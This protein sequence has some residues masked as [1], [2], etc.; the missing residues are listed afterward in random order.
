M[1]TAIRYSASNK[2]DRRVLTVLP[3]CVLLLVFLGFFGATARAQQD[4]PK[5]PPPTRTDSV[6]EDIHGIM[7]A[8]PY[9]W[10]EDQQS[11]E[12]RAW[13]AAENACT[14][15]V[16]RNLAG[17]AAIEKRLTEL[18][19]VDQ[20][21]VPSARHG[22]YFF[23]KR[24][25]GQDLFVLYMRAGR[26]GRDEVLVDPASMSADH[27]T[28]VNFL[29]ASNDGRLV[30]FGVRQGGED[31]ISIRLLNSE[32]HKEL[33]D[34]LPRARY[35]ANDSGSLALKPDKSGFYYSKMTSGG[36]RIFYHSIGSDASSDQEVFGKQYGPDKI[37]GVRLSPDGKYLLY[38]VS[39]GAGSER[40]EVY[41]QNA[42]DNGPVAT[43]VNDVDAFTFARIA[44]DTIYLL[45][46]WNAPRW[47][48]MAADVKNPGRKHWREIIPESDARIEG[49]FLAGGKLL[50][51]YTRNATSQ[52]KVFDTSGKPLG[53]I[54]LP[55][56]GTVG[57][58]HSR[59]DS[60]EVFFSFRSF[61]VPP[62]V[63]R[64][65]MAKK[66]LA[67]WAKANV[68]INSR[69]FVV[70]QVWY[71]S[72]DGTRVPMF[73]FH[74]K[75][76][77]LDGSNPTLLTGYG[78]FDLSETPSFREMAVVWAERGG[79]WAVPNLRGGGEFGEAWHKAGMRDKKQN[80]FD[81]FYAAAEWL[82]RNKYTQP[83][84]LAIQ[85][86]SN[87][88]LLVGAAMTQRPD[89]FRA[90]VCM[91]PLLDMVRFQKFLVARWWVPEY[92]SSDDPEQFKYI[93]AYSPYQHVRPGTKYP[94]VLFI[95]GDGDTRV[96]PLHARKMAAEMQAAGSPRPVL[97]LYDTKSGHSG[98]R[99][100]GKEIE[101]TTDQISFLFWQL[102]VSAM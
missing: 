85:G 15:S 43:V 40:S 49:F 76:L 75:G 93:Y 39:Y 6:K 70:K 4:P 36:A 37:S 7:I 11:P 17:R 2:I 12:T 96:A 9:R 10:L 5:C 62:T 26:E 14:E 87:G 68:P 58:I 41:L 31:E 78:G 32:T 98:G 90:V 16:L 23:L 89:L 1:T 42:S 19:K 29:N 25:V 69:N 38:S 73:L 77:R 100:L 74:K 79:V 59:W 57:G 18:M 60:D 55:A 66:T 95:T 71:S 52:L 21:G 54:G 56:L 44:G 50:V 67:V 27:T 61:A 46:N 30:I 83:A 48:L 35:F 34:R 80:V 8:D 64:Y 82:I 13:I 84:K 20:I 94:A 86:A 33:S 72:K 91:Y 65:D 53:E 101:E 24:E 81:D 22:H 97:L 45:T 51:D 63:Y 3:R 47:R 99:P 102:G 88:G 92:G 28:S